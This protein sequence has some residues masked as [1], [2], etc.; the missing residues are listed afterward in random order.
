MP[1]GIGYTAVQICNNHNQPIY[2]GDAS[3]A[4][5]N[6]N[7]GNTLAAGA[8]VQIWLNAN[9]VLYAVS[10]AITTANSISILYSGV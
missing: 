8:T 2:L 1:E 4:T 10:A 3:V 9:D 7:I 5:S 6:A